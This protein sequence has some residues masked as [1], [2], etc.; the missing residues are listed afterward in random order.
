[1][2]P[3]LPDQ[4]LGFLLHDVSRLLRKRFDRRARDL[5]L[6]RS[7]WRVVAHLARRPGL[8]QT[9]LAELLEMEKISLGRM[10][11]RLEA[12]GWLQRRPHP[13]DR[14]A[15]QLFLTEEVEPVLA[16]MRALSQEI[17]D[18]VQAGLDPAERD[19]LFRALARIKENLL[20][21][22]SES[23]PTE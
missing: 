8:T 7:Q 11:D 22:P 12:A 3:Y 19:H 5:G 6:T 1:M 14:R 13:A 16:R 10:V 18:E 23:D 2:D 9:E 4:S 17:Q 21:E 20:D 15:K